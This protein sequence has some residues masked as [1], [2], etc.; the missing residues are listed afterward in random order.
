MQKKN[1]ED[2]WNSYTEC[3]ICNSNRSSKRYYENKDKISNRPK[4]NIMKQLEINYYTN[5]K[6]DK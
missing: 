4:T 2:P 6:I 3:K 5:K 1:I